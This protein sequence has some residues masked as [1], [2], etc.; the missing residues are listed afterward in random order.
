[1]R[2][3]RHVQPRV[4]R[5]RDPDGETVMRKRPYHY[6]WIYSLVFFALGLFHI[7]FAWL[8]LISFILPLFFA[9]GRGTKGYCNRYCDR[10]Q[11][12]RMFGDELG[13]SRRNELP[14]WMKSGAFRYAVM[15]LFFSTFGSI[16]YATWQ[17]AQGADG[18]QETLTVLWFFRLP[19]HWAYGGGADP[20]AAAFAFKLYGFLLTSEIVAIASMLYF[21]P[22]AWCVYCPMGTLTQ[23][24]CRSKSKA[25]LRE[26]E[27]R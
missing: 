19:W 6:L 14:A 9:F 20:W 4:S 25:Y 26:V 10:G 27:P 15:I 16:L 11:F 12:L 8:G 17:I 23:M 24:I 1:M 13:L 7:M 5:E 3:M 18:L 21:K 22:R 2:G